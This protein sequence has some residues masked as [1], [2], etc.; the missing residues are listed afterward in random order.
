MRARSSYRPVQIADGS[1][2]RV[3]GYTHSQCCDCGLV[4]AE[5]FKI[6]NGELFFRT[7]RDDKETAKQRA[8]LG[9]RITSKVTKAKA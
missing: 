5:E 6:E 3:K 1:W 4:H 9:I 8:A 7:Q 2:Y